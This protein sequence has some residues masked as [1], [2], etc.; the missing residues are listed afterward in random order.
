MKKLALLIACLWVCSPTMSAHAEPV[1]PDGRAMSSGRAMTDAAQKYLAALTPQQLKQVSLSFDDPARRDWHNIPKPVRKGLQIREM[2]PELRVLCHDLL[3]A[4]LSDV[5]YEKAVHIMALEGYLLIGEQG[6]GPFRDPER[7]FLTIFGTPAH[8][9]TWGWSFEGH[10][11]SLNFVI[12]NDQVVGETPSFWGAN[13]ATVKAFI[14]GGPE[15]G[16]R[17]LRDEE[18]LAFDL[19][20]SLTPAQRTKAVIAEKAP[21]DYRN[22]G[23]PTPPSAPQEGLAG[24]ELTPEQQAKLWSLLSTYYNHLEEDIA[25]TRLNEIKADGLENVYF[26]WLGATEPGIGHSY[27]VQGPTFVLELVNIQADPAGNKANHI[28]SVWRSLKRD[29]GDTAR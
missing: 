10:H 29:F 18:Q 17:T 19:V 13:P 5:G 21:A 15:M 14:E 23:K 4:G 11:F 25:T 7:Y 24:S 26:A 20:N 28:H 22:A 6:K 16:V 8:D 2:S 12:Q 1:A 27:R 9:S 3:K